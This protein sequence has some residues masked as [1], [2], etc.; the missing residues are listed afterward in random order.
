MVHDI[1]SLASYRF[2]ESSLQLIGIFYISRGKELRFQIPQ[3][4][5]PVY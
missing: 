5:I 4:E 2:A 1:V 3:I